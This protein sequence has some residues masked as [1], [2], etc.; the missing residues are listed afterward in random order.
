[1][2][3]L[4]ATVED[5]H[6]LRQAGIERVE[7]QKD[8]D[9]NVKKM[10]RRCLIVLTQNSSGLKQYLT[11]AEH[12]Y[13][14]AHKPSQQVQHLPPWGSTVNTSIQTFSPALGIDIC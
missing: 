7:R 5:D 1:M 12:F 14:S 4:K 8:A 10:M 9:V 6:E 3:T 13:L 2:R 11:P